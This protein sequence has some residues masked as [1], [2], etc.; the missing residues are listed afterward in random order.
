MNFDDDELNERVATVLALCA[1]RRRERVER[2]IEML[3]EIKQNLI[4][5]RAQGHGYWLGPPERFP[6][7]LGREVPL[8]HC[9]IDRDSMN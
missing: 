4:W 8:F 9:V 6:S 7:G 2:A 5:R 1:S 3:T